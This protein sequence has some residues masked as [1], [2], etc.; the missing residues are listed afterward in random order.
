MRE[1]ENDAGEEAGLE[2]PGDETQGVERQ[3]CR[4]EH[5]TRGS[6][7]PGHQERANHAAGAEFVQQQ[8]T[9]DAAHDVTDEEDSGAKPINGFAPLQGIEHLESAK[10]TF[11][12]SR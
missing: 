9:L 12:R 8:I 10:P 4:D 7:S 5:Q 11:T 3:R 6:Q 2:D 1:I